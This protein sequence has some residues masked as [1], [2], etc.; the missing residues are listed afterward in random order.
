MP[1]KYICIRECYQK[2]EKGQFRLFK[3]G[4]TAWREVHPGRHWSEL[5]PGEPLT[6][7]EA[8]GKMCEEIG[9][10]VD[11]K[12]DLGRLQREFDQRQIQLHAEQ[13]KTV[14]KDKVG[15]VDNRVVNSPTETY[16]KGK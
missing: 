16:K 9:I 5:P 2:N 8:L 12:W 11:K 3:P 7:V 10:K 15:S 4:E 6:A 1:T 14:M 13:D